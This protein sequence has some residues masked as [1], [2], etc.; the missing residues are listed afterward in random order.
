MSDRLWRGG[1]LGSW[2]VHAGRAGM[3]MGMGD[4]S[5]LIE[6]VST[7]ALVIG[8]VLTIGFA[9]T[10]SNP[11]NQLSGS[12]AVMTLIAAISRTVYAAHVRSG[13]PRR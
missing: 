5:A 12:M 2:M 6:R 7:A 9:V 3:Q 13:E 11:V 1:Q 10:G 8:G 4:R